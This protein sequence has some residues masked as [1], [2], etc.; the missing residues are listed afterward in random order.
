M[1]GLSIVE[2]QAVHQPT[3]ADA[4]ALLLRVGLEHYY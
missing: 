4:V 1:L 2:L 3:D